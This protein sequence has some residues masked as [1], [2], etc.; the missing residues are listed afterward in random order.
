MENEQTYIQICGDDVFFVALVGTSNDPLSTGLL[1]MSVSFLQ[2]H[3]TAAQVAL[4]LPLGTF[5]NMFL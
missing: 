4:H 2:R 1:C 5:R 3:H